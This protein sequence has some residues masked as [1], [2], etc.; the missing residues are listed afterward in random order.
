MNLKI[1]LKN[2]GHFARKHSTKILAGIAVASEFAAVIFA[3]KEGPIAQDRLKELPADAKWTDK[4]KAVG[5]VYL[6]A[7]GMLVL[8]TGCIIGGCAVGEKK[9]AIV[10]GLYSASEAALRDYERKVVETVGKDKAQE[11]QNA[12]AKQCM[13][14]HPISSATIYSTG[15][16]DQIIYDPLS[17]RYFTSDVNEIVKA[18]NVMNKRILNEMWVTVNDWYYEL[19]LE[20]VGLADGYGWN[21]DH[22]IDI[23]T[24]PQCW[25]HTT[26]VDNRSAFMIT[27]YNRPVLYK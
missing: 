13:E 14:E 21:V 17:G 12:V 18:M 8:S 26:T 5:P 2:V 22:L 11:I 27:Y 23:P 6:P 4:L 1:L 24:D 15:K 10:S 9:I 16:G 7:F 20:P 19:G 25:A 3:A